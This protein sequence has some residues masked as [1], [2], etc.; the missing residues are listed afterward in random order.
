MEGYENQLYIISYVVLHRVADYCQKSFLLS[1]N[2]SVT[3]EIL[4]YLF[5]IYLESYDKGRKFYVDKI[6]YS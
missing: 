2:S 5:L 4:L 6:K 1:L 3:T